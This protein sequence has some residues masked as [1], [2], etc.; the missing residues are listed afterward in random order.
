MRVDLLG[1]LRVTIGGAVV[2][3]PML[4]ERALLAALALRAGRAVPVQTLETALWGDHPPQTA[5]RTLQ[6]HVAR[7]RHDLGSDLIVRESAGYRLTLSP[8]AIDAIRLEKLVASGESALGDGDPSCAGRWFREAESLWRGDPL[9]DL[10]DT[11]DR[12]AQVRR[13]SDLWEQAR[14]GRIRTELALGH[15]RRVLGELRRLVIEQPLHEPLWGL[16]I[17]ALYRCG[18]QM[19]ALRSYREVRELLDRELGVDPSPD[20]QRLHAQ[21][22]RQDPQLGLSPPPPP[23]VVPAPTS[24]FVGRAGQVGSVA[25]ALESSRLITLHGPAG[26]GKSRLAQ[27]AARHVRSVFADGI[28]WVDLTVCGDGTDALD[29][30]AATLGVSVAPGQRL[31]QSLADF[32]STRDILVVLDNCEHVVAQLAPG[33]TT[34]LSAAAHLRVLATSRVPLHLSGELLW[35]VR[36]LD[37]PGPGSHDAATRSCDA[38]ALFCERLGR[39]IEDAGTLTQAERLCRTLDGIPLALELVAVR[40]RHRTLSEVC[41]QLDIEVATARRPQAHPAHHADVTRAIDWSYSQLDAGA[42]HL[43]DWLAVFPADLDRQA[44]EAVGAALPGTAAGAVAELL[45]RLLDACMIE[46][47]PVGATTRYR[48]HFVMR[49][50]ARARLRDRGETALAWRAFADHYRALCTDAAAELNCSHPGAWLHTLQR[51]LVNLRAAL[52]WSLANETGQRSPVYAPAL[53]RVLWLASVDLAAD[54]RLL[55]REV[56]SASGADPDLLGWGWQALVTTTY[57]SGD[58]AAALH[59]C[60]RA[61]ALFEQAGDPAGLAAV[62]WHRGAALMLAAGDLAAADPALRRG[63][64]LARVAA[65]PT[66]EAW[67]LAHLVQLAYFSDRVTQESFALQAEAESLADCEDEVIQS[68]LAMNRAGLRIASGNL[69]AAANAARICEE[70]AHHV[71]MRT[72]EQAG[73]LLLGA[74]LLALDRVEEATA[75]ALRAARLAMEASNSMQFGFALQQLARITEAEDPARAAALWGAATLRSP[76]L[77]LF[78]PVLFPTGAAE[79]LGDRFQAEVAAGRSL[80]A[81]QALDLAIG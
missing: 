59:A 68:H 9:T 20:L 71:G 23:F 3:S 11:P 2:A 10:A 62:H 70:Y 75:T 50:F 67:C 24:S 47:R 49:E 8:N 43:F 4:K 18:D 60:A 13:L 79:A 35:D 34:L 39:P 19:D 48:L 51:E 36:P 5:A 1:P 66:V 42:Q 17:L 37:V 27:E 15:H 25:A 16:F 58:L 69:A 30:L 53:G 65:V 40:A 14:E 72:Y 21:I 6:A 57:L 26:V 56:Q 44:L 22:L 28:W 31:V 74:S 80:A 12:Q 7:L 81:E 45:D 41:G 76:V 61:A 63:R 32:L 77:P 73:Q 78:E 38:L 29:T 33:L 46:A 54:A 52:A 64:D 55:A